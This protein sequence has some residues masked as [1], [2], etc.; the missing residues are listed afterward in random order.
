M[1]TNEGKGKTVVVGLSGGVDSSVA[2]LLLKQQG[3]NVVGLF[4]KNWEDDDDGEYCST[5][6]DLI[7][8]MSV[9]DTIGI[10][11]EVVNFAKEYRERVF[12]IFLEEYKAGRTPNP[13]VLCN[14]EIKFKAFLDH[15]LQMGADK[16]A[17]GH[18]AGVREFN[19]KF[20]LLKA[21]DGTKDQSYFLHR[22][23]Q[24]QLSKTLFPLADIYKRDVRKMAEDAGLHVAVKKDSTGICFIGERPFKEF[25]MRYLPPKKGEIRCLD[26]ARVLGE[27]DGLTFHTLGQRK[28]LHI[29]GTKSYGKDGDHEAWFV[30]KKDMAKNILYVVQGHD[31][32]ALLSEQ[33]NANQLS[34]IS[35]EQPHTHWVY[36]AKTRYRQPD[37]PCEIERVDLDSC[38]INFAEA[39]WAVTP[40]QSVVV[41]E[42]R[43]C[44]GGGVIV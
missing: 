23:N 3:W 14:S 1:K 22:L 33:L 15:A 21:E 42:S 41:Y 19:G 11:V 2:A 18:Y 29:G 20:Q 37:A 17:T 13:D 30:A 28:G 36:A 9:A 38:Q 8:V 40:G 43:V 31:H 32:P 35:G 44:L 39:Q 16:I 4:M 10:D 12:S 25:L 7:D 34:W 24:Q 27:H 6:Q 5:R 26:D